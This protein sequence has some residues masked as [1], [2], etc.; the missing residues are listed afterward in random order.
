MFE[1]ELDNFLICHVDER[2]ITSSNKH[3]CVNYDE[4]NL[5]KFELVVKYYFSKICENNREDIRYHIHNNVYDLFYLEYVY[6]SAHSSKSYNSVNEM[7]NHVP[8]LNISNQFGFQHKYILK[9][10]RYNVQLIHILYENDLYVFTDDMSFGHCINYM[11]Y[12]GMSRKPNDNNLIINERM[13]I[14]MENNID[15]LMKTISFITTTNAREINN[16]EFLFYNG[17]NKF[18]DASRLN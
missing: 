7:V 18:N 17:I 10:K 6:T 2:L 5:Q 13:P 16:N 8:R 9:K 15:I 1:L 4:L 12:D 14:N 3:I 11:F